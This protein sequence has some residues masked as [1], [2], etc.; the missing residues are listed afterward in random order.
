MLNS[1]DG[2]WPIVTDILKLFK[3]RSAHADLIVAGR[4]PIHGEAALSIRLRRSRSAEPRSRHSDFGLC[5][6]RSTGIMHH[7]LNRGSHGAGGERQHKYKSANT[8]SRSSRAADRRRR[9]GCR[10]R[11]RSAPPWRMPFMPNAA[12]R[13]HVMTARFQLVVDRIGNVGLHVQLV[14]TRNCAARM[15]R[16]NAGS[17]R[18]ATRTPRAGSDTSRARTRRRR[19]TPGGSSAPGCRRP[20]D[21]DRHEGL[22]VAQHDARR[23]RVAR[24][25]ARPQLRRARLVEPELLAAHAHADPG[26]AEDHGA[27]DPAAAR[28][29]VEDVAVLIDDGDVGGVLVG[30]WRTGSGSGTGPPGWPASAS[31]RP[32]SSTL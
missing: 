19:G 32:S 7:T 13:A 16:R 17:G 23:E 30:T 4:E 9:S 27:A 11:D 31:S 18:A 12:H 15:S 2:C 29:R 6:H 8:R 10:L 28:R 21:A 22:A 1:T 24:S 20:G 14:E 3:T 26:I 25:R 5:D